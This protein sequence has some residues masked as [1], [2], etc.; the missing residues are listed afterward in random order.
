MAQ[1]ILGGRKT[2][3]RRVVASKHPVEFL[4]GR[5]QEAD[6]SAW[7][8]SFD[9]PEHSGYMVLARGMDERHDNGCI[10]IPCPYGVPGDRLWVR[11]TWYCDHVFAGDHAKTCVGCVR[12]SHTDADRIAQ[13]REELYY[14]A[15]GEPD[16]E[17]ERAEW[18]PSIHMPRWASRLALE[19]T[20]VRVQ[21]LQDISEEDARAEGL[22]SCPSRALPGH[23]LWR[24]YGL[25]ER[26]TFEWYLDPRKSF[27]TLW[28]SINGERPGC[29]WEAN[30][31]VWAVSFKVAR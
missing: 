10:S 16:F 22:S 3:T 17:G 13:W 12:C 15:D 1:A 23:L 20:E 6:L 14:R 5:G 24:D 2:Q 29:S 30:P 26:D 21:R 11:E 18:K 4:G 28:Q 31:W 7:G 27:Q 8:W 25:P 9:G 19:V